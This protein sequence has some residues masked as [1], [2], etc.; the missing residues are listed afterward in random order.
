MKM[1]VFDNQ[2]LCKNCSKKM[3]KAEAIKNGFKM[4]AMVCDGCNARVLHPLDEAEYNKFINLK[5]REFK[6]KMRLVGNSYA[7]SIPKEIVCFMREQEK[8]FN[9]MVRLCFDEAN[10]LSLHFD[11]MRRERKNAK[12]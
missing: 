11:K 4:R 3:K 1:D 10:R 7:V 2:I 6:V 8:M 12:E 5:N 9:D